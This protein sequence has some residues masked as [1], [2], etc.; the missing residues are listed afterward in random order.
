M[1]KLKK[2]IISSNREQ[3]LYKSISKIMRDFLLFAT[4]TENTPDQDCCKPSGS[5]V[6]SKGKYRLAKTFLEYFINR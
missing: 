6:H 4:M 3:K 5:Q 1:N 2:E